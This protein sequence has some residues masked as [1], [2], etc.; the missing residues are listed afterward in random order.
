[1]TSSGSLSWL[2]ILWYFVCLFFF[3]WGLLHDLFSNH[4]ET[5]WNLQC[6][7][8]HVAGG[9][10]YTYESHRALFSELHSQWP[11]LRGLKS[12][13]VEWHALKMNSYPAGHICNHPLDHIWYC[14][15]GLGLLIDLEGSINSHSFPVRNVN[16]ENIK[17]SFGL[18]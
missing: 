15:L 6:E 3:P 1:M 10:A 12:T 16:P 14:T 13:V 5:D 2:H 18:F 7:T 9:K 8:S 4:G 17:S 11:H